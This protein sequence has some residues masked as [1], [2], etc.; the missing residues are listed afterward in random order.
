MDVYKT[1]DEQLET[2]KKWWAEN[3]KSAV[4]GIVLGLGGI[5]GWRAWQANIISQAEAASTIYEQ[6]II[7]ANQGNVTD[8]RNYAGQIIENYGKTGYA[9]FASLILAKL[10][11]EESDY[12]GAAEHLSRALETV[13]QEPLRHEIRLR[14]ARIYIADNKLDQAMTLLNTGQ[15]GAFS[16]V[17]HEL[18]GDIHVLQNKPAEAR[19]AYQ[20]AILEAQSASIDQSLL[21][22][23]L[24][25]VGN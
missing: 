1:E 6:S 23:K 25:S 5:F 13:G 12:S 7:A 19:T 24:D 16:P 4:F 22:I 18:K 8:A 14:L 17:Y 2:F 9:V 15:T 10:A 3:G 11:A 21:N 20:Q